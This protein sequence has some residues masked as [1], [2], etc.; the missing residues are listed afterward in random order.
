MK[1]SAVG[2]TYVLYANTGATGASAHAQTSSDRTATAAAL[3]PLNA[4]T[5]L[6]AVS[7][8][9]NTRGCS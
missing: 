6:A 9:T 5:H 2:H 8:G 4:W 1:A 7:D 3:S